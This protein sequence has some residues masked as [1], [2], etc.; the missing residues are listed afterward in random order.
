MSSILDAL[1]KLEAE[2]TEARQREADRSSDDV[3]ERELVGRH[4]VR[5]RNT[6][7][8]TP[9]AVVL[10]FLVFAALL[11]GTSVGVSMLLVSRS[12]EAAPRDVALNV[13]PQPTPVKEAQAVHVTESPPVPEPAP[14]TPTQTGSPQPEVQSQ[15][16]KIQRPGPPPAVKPEAAAADP[17]PST[18]SPT[19]SPQPEIQSQLAKAQDPEPPPPAKPEATIPKPA[20][21]A[22]SSTEGPRPVQNPESKSQDPDQSWQGPMMKTVSPARTSPPEAKREPVA[23]GPA[24]PA[25]DIEALAK[26][27]LRETDK[28]RLGLV[29]LQINMLQPVNKK[30]PL[31]SAIINLNTVYVGEIVPRTTAK[32]IA[33]DGIKGIVLE[34]LD[35]KE[36]FYVP[37]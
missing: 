32:L 3:A 23:S 1:K 14:G 31:A 8:V 10:G 33:V 25:L 5:P 27:P 9:A 29:G 35:T 22:P 15:T 6:V 28:R 20:P 18:P 11:V 19:D 37:F 12:N 7:R 24:P 13:A 30:R 36:R 26:R 17:V 16:P 34:M 4:I 21:A 2:K